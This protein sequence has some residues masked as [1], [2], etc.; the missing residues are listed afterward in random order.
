MQTI[1]QPYGTHVDRLIVWFLKQN[2]I[3]YLFVTHDVQSGFVTHKKE[4][5]DELIV[6][7]EELEYISVYSNEISA[8]RR[9]LNIR[10]DR[11]IL[12]IF[13]WCSD[14]VLR[15]AKIF[16]EYMAC[17]TIFGVTKEQKNLFLLL[18]L[19]I[20]MKCSLICTVSCHQRKQRLIIG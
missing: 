11:T 6:E 7:D 4:K 13:A 1:G 17:G 3:S 10:D 18:E 19:M 12:V 20:T 9:N 2:D 14:E 16:P 5:R 8:W 15:L